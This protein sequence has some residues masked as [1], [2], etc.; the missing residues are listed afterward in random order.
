VQRL[1][2]YMEANAG[3][4]PRPL[5][6]FDGSLVVSF[7]GQMAQSQQRRY[8]TA[9]R[10][11]LAASEATGVPVVGFVDTSYATDQTVM[12]ARL[13]GFGPRAPVSDAAL[14][15]GRMAWGERSHVYVCARDDQVTDKYYDRVCFTYLKTNESN[16]PARIDFPRWVYEAGEHGRMLDLVR[17]ECVV[18]AGYP[19]PLETA[20]A[21]AVLTFEDRERFYRLFQQ[22]AERS[23]LPLRFSRKAV[24]KRSRR[25]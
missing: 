9:I 13:V 17:A 20:D 15:G 8:T 23:R 1:I 5:A 2:T 22:F 25:I 19:Y 14:L 21:T 11:L 12:L 16:A 10:A 24:S 7:A 6:F 4:T 18:G 3:A